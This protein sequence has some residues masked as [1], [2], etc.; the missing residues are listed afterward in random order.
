MEAERNEIRGKLRRLL[1]QADA[2]IQQRELFLKSIIPR[3]ET[4]LQ[5]AVADCRGNRSDFSAVVE[6]YREQLLSETQFARIEANLAGIV[7]QIDR[8]IGCSEASSSLPLKS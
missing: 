3:L 2:P 6:I 8:T 5:I 7:A 1:T 4:T